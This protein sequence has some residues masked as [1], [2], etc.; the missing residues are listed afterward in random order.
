MAPRR[1]SL[2]SPRQTQLT[3]FFKPGLRPAVA[4][5]QRRAVRRSRRRPKIEYNDDD[6]TAEDEPPAQGSKYMPISI[7]DSDD[8]AE[9]VLRRVSEG[10]VQKPKSRRGRLPW[11]RKITSPVPVVQ[12]A[13][14]SSRLAAGNPPITSP[15]YRATLLPRI[16]E[17]I[18]PNVPVSH[19]RLSAMN[20]SNADILSDVYTLIGAGRAAMLKPLIELLLLRQPVVGHPITIPTYSANPTAFEDT[21]SE[22]DP[23]D[24]D[25]S[26]LCKPFGSTE[27]P[28]VVTLHYAAY[29]TIQPRYG[30]AYDI[31]SGC[32]SQV[33]RKLGLET[34]TS[35]SAKQGVLIFYV[36]SRRL[37]TPVVSYNK[38]TFGNEKMADLTVADLRLTTRLWHSSKARACLLWDRESFSSFLHAARSSKWIVTEV[39]R[40]GA[41]GSRG[42]KL[43]IDG[44][45]Y[46]VYTSS[47]DQILGEV[48][49]VVITPP[50]LH[51]FSSLATS[52]VS[53]MGHA[54][55]AIERL[56][57]FGTLVAY[58]YAPRPTYL[59]CSDNYWLYWPT[60]QVIP[61]TDFTCP[62]NQLRNAVV[63]LLWLHT[64]ASTAIL[65]AW[66]V[67]CKRFFLQDIKSILSV[68]K[69]KATYPGAR[70]L[71][72][73]PTHIA[74]TFRSNFGGSIPLFEAWLKNR[75]E[76]YATIKTSSTGA[77]TH[78][79][80]RSLFKAQYGRYPVANKYL[81]PAVKPQRGLA[82]LHGNDPGPSSNDNDPDP[83][84][85]DSDASG[86]TFDFDEESDWEGV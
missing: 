31:S 10:R 32:M 25:M 85:D 56:I 86:V 28:L 23:P 42:L 54:C 71:A 72:T 80:L 51:R 39:A 29:V 63:R 58:G 52:F 38:S 47:E 4:P 22:V 30:S 76:Q 64:C 67:Y 12:T 70:S 7:D 48:F 20:P 44:S 77:L 19:E 50:P 61:V 62:R 83:S 15:M 53:D 9:D 37:I 60:C 8:D 16:V 49:R 27:A 57:D 73:A 41:Q 11:L 6:S 78:T 5:P 40:V 81:R 55:S 26:L 43:S 84:S 18:N 34:Q 1:D 74:A 65:R 79:T 45:V 35:R 69:L 75:W 24:G 68:L 3:A 82:L 33:L 66:L 17:S 36:I 46:L 13:R 21:M 59:S 14:T 2:L